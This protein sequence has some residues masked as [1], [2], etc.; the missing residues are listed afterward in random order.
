MDRET[1]EVT[2]LTDDRT[3]R[4]IAADTLGDL[5]DVVVGADRVAA[6]IAAMRAE[7]IDTCRRFAEVTVP[8]TTSA[9]M[10]PWSQAETARRT[11]VSELACAMRL[12]ER[13]VETLVMESRMLVHELPATLEALRSGET[14]YRH[15]KS[16]IDHANSLPEEQRAGFEA[17]VLPSAATLTVSQFDRKARTI[18]ERMDPASIAERHQ[19][20]VADRS[21]TVENGRDGMAWLT[22][23]LAAV[24]AHA[25]YNRATE[26]A[27]RPLKGDDRTLTQRR[28]DYAVGLLLG[29]ETAGESGVPMAGEQRTCIR[30][31]VAIT[32]PVLSLLGHGDELATLGGYGPIDIDTARRLVGN[33]TSFLR[34]LTHPETG[35]VLSVGQDRYSVPADLRA[36]LRL[37]DGRCRKPGCSVAAARCDLDHCQEWQH[38]GQ[39]AHDNLEHL[40]PKHHAEKHHTAWAVRHLGDGDIEWTSPAGRVY[41]DEPAVR[42]S[43]HG[44][45]KIPRG[46]NASRS[47]DSP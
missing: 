6:T 11:L 20:S 36:W 28:V 46:T 5:V 22:L 27:S 32:V 44:A 15:A 18:R 47:N 7:Q 40:C 4:A 34:V 3:L 30:P 41:I 26:A 19:K 8:I 42:I 10:T 38:G 33:A 45:E 9:G 17:A 31:W 12:P 37:R 29:A 1:A 23:H 16:I 21:I 13:T 25:I 39:T 14:S 43:I 24:D 35:V 2:Q